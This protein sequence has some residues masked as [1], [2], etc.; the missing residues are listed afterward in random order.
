MDMMDE[1]AMEA[2]ASVA[3][4][5]DIL[6][7]AIAAAVKNIKTAAKRKAEKERRN[8]RAVGCYGCSFM[9]PNWFLRDVQRLNRIFA[10]VHPCYV[11]V[12]FLW[13]VCVNEGLHV[14]ARLVFEPIQLPWGN[15]HGVECSNRHTQRAESKCGRLK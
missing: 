10:V 2:A 11:V 15:A 9:L 3:A 12:A 13:S 7:R 5:E 6:R 14:V 8:L 1:S 4:A